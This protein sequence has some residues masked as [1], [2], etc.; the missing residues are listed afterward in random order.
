M[1]SWDCASNSCIVHFTF[2]TG[3]LWTNELLQLWSGVETFEVYFFLSQYKCQCPPNHE[4][5]L[6]EDIDFFCAIAYFSFL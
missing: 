2:W 5:I 1:G 4:G 3:H 6:L